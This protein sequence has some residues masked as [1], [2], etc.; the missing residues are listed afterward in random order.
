MHNSLSSQISLN[1]VGC[2]VFNLL[3]ILLAKSLAWLC[4]WLSIKMLYNFFLSM[5]YYVSSYFTWCPIRNKT[6]YRM[7][8]LNIQMQN[9]YEYCI[10]NVVAIVIV[11]KL[12]PSS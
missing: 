11:A 12:E 4:C 9:K 8:I 10:F 5:L 2:C 6:K 3:Y 1:T 7:W